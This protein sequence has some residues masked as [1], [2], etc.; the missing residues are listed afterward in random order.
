MI[1]KY[2][3]ARLVAL[4][5]IGIV[6]GAGIFA[7]LGMNP[8]ATSQMGQQVKT[9]SDTPGFVR[10]SGDATS[11][12]HSDP[13][14]ERNLGSPSGL[15]KPSSMSVHAFEEL[16]YPFLEERKYQE[17]NWSVDKSL[18]DTGPYIDGKSYGTH[19]AVRVYYSPEVILWLMNGRKGNIPDGAMIIK[20]QYEEPAARHYGKS[21]EELRE[22]LKSWTVMI[23]DAHG[24]HDGWFWSNPYPSGEG[25]D[26]GVKVVNNHEYPFYHPESGFGHYCVRCHAA[27]KSPE[28]KS[29]S[30]ENEFTFSSLRNIKGFPGEPIIFRVDDSWREDEE[31]HAPTEELADDESNEDAINPDIEMI[32]ASVAA[33]VA[34]QA[35][36]Q[37]TGTGVPESCELSL[38]QSFL[39]VFGQIGKQT[40]EDVLH[41]PPV[42]HD[43]VV[44][45]AE[46]KQDLITSNQCMSCHAGLVAPYGP[47][48]FIGLEKGK[49]AYKD[50]GWHVSPYG[51]WRWS[52]MG[53][54]GRDP[55]FYAQL[56]S[57][58]EILKKE[59]ANDEGMASEV[60]K[61]LVDTCLRC[62]GA[63]GK[64]QFDMDKT[65]PDSKFTIDHVYL[66]ADEDKHIGHGDAKYGAL[67]RDGISCM[68]CHRSQPR[69]Q[70][71]DDDR[72][73][74]QYF[75]ETSITGNFHLGPP[76]EIYGPF[77]DDEISPYAMEHATAIKPKHNDYI[78]SSQMCGTCH[79]VTLPSVD[80]P[81]GDETPSKDQQELIKAE[82]VPLFKKF[83]HHVEQATYL[84]WLNSEFENEFNVSNP[85]AQSCQ[86]C[87]MSQGLVD[88]EAGIE[89]EQIKTR[90]ATIQDNTYPDAENLA[91]LEEL[92]IRLRE[93]GYRRHNFVGLNVFLVELF[94]QYDEVLG[95]RKNDF[96]TGSSLDIDHA[97]K[98]FQRQATE[99]VVDMSLSTS[100]E[101]NTLSATVDIKNKVGHRFPSGVGFRRA[102]L[103]LLVVEKQDDGEEKIVWSSGRTDENGIILG[104]DG[105]HLATEFF[106][107]DKETGEQPHQ[108]HHQ[109]ITS[110]DQV[111]IYETLLHSHDHSF[112]TSFI[113]GCFTIK[114]N[115]LLPR[116]WK[117]EGPDPALTG[118][119]LK[120][121]HPGEEAKKDP[122]YVNGSGSDQIVYKIEL[123]E[124]LNADNLS[125]KVSMYYQ[126]FPPYFLKNLFDN[127]PES[128]AV[129]RLHY[130]I[131]NANVEGTL[132]E[133]WKFLINSVQADIS[134]AETQTSSLD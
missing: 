72:P 123:P 93:E 60:A 29:P 61:N 55:I 91:E 114:E 58:I 113:H 6:L 125:V 30:E 8:R 94:R 43:W 90:I 3:T 26:R 92:N 52:P 57:E 128:Q 107:K 45:G 87:H 119:Y 18:R 96:M 129:Q 81:F 101:S 120:A 131:S 85:K 53:L 133:D 2:S 9:A 14:K 21:E 19:P 54:A 46:G 28:A 70:P 33:D 17:L 130:M 38:N 32:L 115:R 15:P 132:I 76:D 127:A 126:A 65:D 84:E 124:G 25:E 78:K 1:Q 105:K 5:V 22:S 73:Y 34:P 102:F 63:M 71:E 42:T 27:T 11:S 4:A 40:K 74:L 44:K 13:G 48:M 47:A 7:W 88:K 118:A 79:T 56:E 64:H 82:V 134:P 109:V 95:V 122:R 86:D 35:H 121:T 50:P 62:H 112:T 103:E 77:K 68:V 37:C 10:T 39:D 31:E 110:Q 117:A 66:T 41:L 89:I 67:A 69:E 98:N 59:F 116:G 80:H 100:V 111:Q 36:P 23:K 49:H 108:P 16:M 20:E 12:K 97:I 51:E 99:D 24:S 104:A 83:H 106:T 75:L